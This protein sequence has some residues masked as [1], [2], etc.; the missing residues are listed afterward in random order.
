MCQSYIDIYLD[1]VNLPLDKLLLLGLTCL[2]I[3]MKMEE[4]DLVS[5]RDMLTANRNQPQIFSNDSVAQMEREV[6]SVLEFKLI[7]DTLYFWF[8]LAVQLW[9]LFLRVDLPHVGYHLF[10]PSPQLLDLNRY[11]PHINA[12]QLSRPNPYR[13][14]V[15]ALDLMSM[16][17]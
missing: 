17:I 13:V 15:Q 2:H 8:D 9:D 12:F 1:K 5:L 11:E 10:K 14:A 4:V 16:H 6:V 3:A 7:P